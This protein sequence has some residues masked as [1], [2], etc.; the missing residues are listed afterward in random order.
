M[1]HKLLRCGK[2][3]RGIDPTICRPSVRQGSL[4]GNFAVVAFSLDS[5]G[6]LAICGN[7]QETEAFYNHL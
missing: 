1:D 3:K 5:K 4:S 6:H 2:L 7:L